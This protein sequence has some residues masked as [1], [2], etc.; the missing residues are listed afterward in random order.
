MLI[1]HNLVCCFQRIVAAI[2]VILWTIDEITVNDCGMAAFVRNDAIFGDKVK[3]RSGRL[4]HKNPRDIRYP[5]YER[6]TTNIFQDEWEDFDGIDT[7]IVTDKINVNAPDGRT[8]AIYTDF[9]YMTTGGICD[10][11]GT[12]KDA[13]SKFVSN[14]N[15]QHDCMNTNIR[16]RDSEGRTYV[17]IGKTVFY[18]KDKMPNITGIESIR[19]ISMPGKWIVQ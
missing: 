2:T 13:F 7:D 18:L 14:N 4:M 1:Q 6:G 3:I 16:Y 12:N 17:R 10:F 15:C 19:S 11:S 8:F 9:V 5:D